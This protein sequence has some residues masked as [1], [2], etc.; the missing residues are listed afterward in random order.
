MPW[1]DLD[2]ID[3]NKFMRGNYIPPNYYTPLSRTDLRYLFPN[4]EYE[5]ALNV[6][7]NEII[8][9][10][11]NRYRHFFLISNVTKIENWN[12]E[13]SAYM[14]GP[15]NRRPTNSIIRYLIK[16]QPYLAYIAKIGN[17]LAGKAEFEKQEQLYQLDFPTPR[18][19]YWENGAFIN[20]F[21][22]LFNFLNHKLGKNAI[23]AKEYNEIA[24][25]FDS[26]LSEK[27]ELYVIKQK[28]KKEFFS[29]SSGEFDEI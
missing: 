4:R 18:P 12:L 5:M 24:K 13:K 25:I 2:K 10:Y 28:M 14:P 3:L 7:D 29:N 21:K 16:N 27:E 1:I 9:N 17:Y 6:M 8:K 23:S 11:F 19:F 22:G 20:F 26:I 15:G